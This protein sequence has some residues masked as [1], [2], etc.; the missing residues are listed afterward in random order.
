MTLK[1]QESSQHPAEAMTYIMKMTLKRQE[2][3]NILQKL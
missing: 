1:R 2:A 3:V